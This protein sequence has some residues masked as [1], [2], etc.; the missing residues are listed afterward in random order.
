MEREQT[1]QLAKQAGLV[2]WTEDGNWSAVDCDLVRFANLIAAHEREQCAMVCEELPAPDIYDN[3]DKSMWD[4]TSMDC[5][6]AI[7]N[8]GKQ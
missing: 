8:R 5:A 4:V 7:R 1:L 2:D 6:D 3:T